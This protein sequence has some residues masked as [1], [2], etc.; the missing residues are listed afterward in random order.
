MTLRYGQEGRR[1][2]SPSLR[3]IVVASLAAT[4]VMLWVA[5]A[6]SAYS[7]VIFN[8]YTNSTPGYSG[9]RHS[10]TKVDV[11]NNSP[12]AQGYGNA[13]ENAINLDGTWAQANPYCASPGG[14]YTYHVFCGCQLRYGWV[15]PTVNG[16]VGA[17]LQGIEYY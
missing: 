5:G 15:G 11:Q 17:Y 10:L 7:L 6:A 3:R 2:I 14:I 16:S 4:T 8:G 1:L 12:L 9:P 13:C